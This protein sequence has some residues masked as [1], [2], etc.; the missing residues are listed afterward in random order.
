MRRVARFWGPKIASGSHYEIVIANSSK[1]MFN[2]K[3]GLGE[4]LEL[5]DVVTVV[6]ETYGIMRVYSFH[7]SKLCRSRS[8]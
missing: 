6:S 5:V 1:G 8:D 3:N 7:E 2:E 4:L